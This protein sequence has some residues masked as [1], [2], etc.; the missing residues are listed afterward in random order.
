MK[1]YIITIFSN[2]DSM[3]Y[4]HRVLD[5]IQ[6][7]G[8]E[9]T[10]ELFPAVTPET[11]VD[12]NYT[13][14]LETKTTCPKTGMYLTPYK[15]Y[16]NKKRISAAQSHFK[17]WER[18]VLLD[19]PIMILEHDALFTNKFIEPE[20]DDSIGAYSINDPREA[21][22]LGHQYHESLQDGLNEIPWVTRKEI[23]QGLPGNSA[24]VIKPWAAQQLI[25]AQQDIGYWPNDAIM[26]K[27]L[28]KWLRVH[29]PYF[30]KTQG[31]KSTT[32]K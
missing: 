24:Y 30:T 29:K 2:K 5:S 23:P 1:A 12:V 8:S 3:R 16:D 13:W 19:Q 25:E 28:F 32:S 7:T 27:Q 14:P 10:V 6:E 26:C 15:T 22:F 17:L 20:T 11:M 18:C 31:I 21:T 4:A 9:L